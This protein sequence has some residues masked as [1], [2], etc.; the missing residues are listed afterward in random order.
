MTARA[1]LRG[2]IRATLLLLQQRN[3]NMARIRNDEPGTLTKNVETA[4][5]RPKQAARR[6]SENVSGGGRLTEKETTHACIMGDG[7]VSAMRKAQMMNTTAIDK[8][9]RR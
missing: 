8:G 3:E 4:D 5:S 6:E 7:P 1:Q 9:R 2:G